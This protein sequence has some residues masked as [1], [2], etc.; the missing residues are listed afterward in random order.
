MKVLIVG[1]FLGSKKLSSENQWGCMFGEVEV[2][3]EVLT[4]NV[5]RCQAP[6]LHAPGRIPFYVT[7]CNRLACSEVREFEYREKPPNLSVPDAITA[8]APEDEIRLQMRLI[9]LLNLGVEEKWLNC[10]IQ[11]CEKCQI[12]SLINSER[13]N[14][15]KWRMMKGISTA[16]KS[17]QMTPRDLMIQTLLEDKLCEWL[18]CKVH[19]GT[20]GTHVLDDEGQ[21]VIHL[22]AALG[23]E[24][25]IGPL[26]ASGISP[27]FR[28]SNGRTALH[29]ASYFG[30]LD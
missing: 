4:N 16:L 11:K 13:S 20:R 24:W 23:Y 29:W 7:C 8:S 1:S 5:L 9:S 30:R 17:E 3:A 10:S 26:V 27:N 12:R 18:V 25:A 6:P 19:E 21:G 28:D 2:P 14:S 22:A 15:A